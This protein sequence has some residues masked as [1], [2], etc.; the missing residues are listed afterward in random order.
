MNLETIAVRISRVEKPIWDVFLCEH[1]PFYFNDLDTDTPE[2]M[3]VSILDQYSD[4]QEK[5]YEMADSHDPSVGQDHWREVELINQVRGQ[6]V[7]LDDDPLVEMFKG[8][9]ESFK[10]KPWEKAS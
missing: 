9:A 8:I 1:L 7:V 10:P 5:M 6:D 2:E 4:F 3:F